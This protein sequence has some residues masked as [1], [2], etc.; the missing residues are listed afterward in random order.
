[1]GTRGNGRRG[2]P[3]VT[4]GR[5]EYQGTTGQGANTAATRNLSGGG[6]EFESP[7][8]TNGA[9]LAGVREDGRLVDRSDLLDGVAHS[10]PWVMMA[11]STRRMPRPRFPNCWP[12]SPHAKGI[13]GDVG[14]GASAPGGLVGAGY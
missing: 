8:S 10:V 3:T 9:L 6:P 11:P 5:H 2:T 1:V 4:S 14:Q 7:H 12:T 13:G